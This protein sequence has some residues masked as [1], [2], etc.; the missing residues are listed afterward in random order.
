MGLGFKIG[1]GFALVAAVTVGV[2]L[3]GFVGVGRMSASSAYTAAATQAFVAMNEVNRSFGKFLASGVEKDGVEA[4][5]SIDAVGN[6]IN[7]IDDGSDSIHKAADAL[8]GLKSQIDVVSKTNANIVTALADMD[9][10]T[11][12]L[13]AATSEAVRKA[14]SVADAAFERENKAIEQLKAMDKAQPPVDLLVQGIV[15]SRAL[16]YRFVSAG[17]E[18]AASELS[19]K[20]D[21]LAAP[22]G[23]AEQ[24]AITPNDAKSAVQL[25]K[26]M[27][28]ATQDI[29]ELTKLYAAA[30]QPDASEDAKKAFAD[31][32]D[33]LLT[34]FD[35]AAIRADGMRSSLF[36]GRR[37]AIDGLTAA[38]KERG[39]AK[40]TAE[41]GQMLGTEVASMVAVTKDYLASAGRGDANTV[42][43]RIAAVMDSAKKSDAAGT[44][45]GAVDLVGAY[46]KAFGTIVAAL[47][48]RAGVLSSA[49]WSV[50]D[51]VASI[52]SITSRATEEASATSAGT[53]LMSIVALVVGGLIA[54][55]VA[56]V[57]VRIVRN[58]VTALTSVMRRLADG[59][60]TLE[61][62]GI[63]RGDEIGEMARTVEVF[64]A[65]AVEKARLE[66]EAAKEAE[67][68]AVHQTR[69]DGMIASFRGEIEQM[70]VGVSGQM[71]RMQDVSKR[72]RETASQSQDQ[73]RSAEQAS[74]T[75]SSSAGSV[76]AAAEQ[77]SGSVNEIAER[78]HRTVGVV[79][80]AS[81]QAADSNV[82]IAG[83]AASAGR[84]GDVVKLIRSIAEQTNLLALNATIEAARAG[85]AG[86]GFAV[87]A[88][89]VKQL[90]DQTAK[91]TQEIA[92]QVDDIQG[93]T[94]DA[95]TSIGQIADSMREVNSF[96]ASIAS[97]VEEQGAATAEISQSAHRASDGSEAANRSMDLLLGSARDTS[98]A[99]EEVSAAA[100]Q[101]GEANEALTQTIDH[102]LKAVATA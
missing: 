17:D 87:V 57:T 93:A 56:L 39:I 30:H 78:V 6:L 66:A 54:I 3:I 55:L 51:A 73:A 42:A 33:G 80:A 97:A 85:D 23:Q 95:V 100:Q 4:A 36:M 52:A 48:A 13:A 79:T 75:A 98:A 101:V 76:A 11:A 41:V 88:A 67:E 64:R 32:V 53:R 65:G 40:T 89:E 50:A 94:R 27:K 84:I 68:R 26:S 47:D 81:S 69:I 28:I 5:K 92:T 10:G 61:A 72:L 60:T 31:A 83:L 43:T 19:L 37:Q 45:K 59:D 63:G 99:T 70:L 44:T 58:P 24:M 96:T 8:S 12:A 62:P 1:A 20:V 46:A 49:D 15:N 34:R 9:K 21:G 18:S 2:G 22:I 82:R 29:G 25:G 7:G 91:A 14:N 38:L 86:K 16:I 102:F 90:A 77:L 71:R 35:S 74:S